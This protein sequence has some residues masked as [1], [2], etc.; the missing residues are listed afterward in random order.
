LKFDFHELG[1]GPRLGDHAAADVGFWRSVANQE[2]NTDRL[3]LTQHNL[4][5]IFF[6]ARLRVP[7]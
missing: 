4:L 5:L 6:S 3:L 2:V 7:R 1:D